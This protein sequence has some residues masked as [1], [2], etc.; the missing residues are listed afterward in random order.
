M[1]RTDDQSSTSEESDDEVERFEEVMAVPPPMRIDPFEKERERFIDENRKFSDVMEAYKEQRILE[2]AWTQE[3]KEI[4]LQRF[5]FL[6][7]QCYSLCS[8][9]YAL[10]G[11]FSSFLFFFCYQD[12][13][14][15][16]FLYSSVISIP[17]C[18]GLFFLH[19]MQV[20][21]PNL[22]FFQMMAKLFG[23]SF[24]FCCCRFFQ[25]PKDF[26]RIASFIPGKTVKDCVA[27]YVNNKYKLKL[28]MDLWSSL[29]ASANA[30]ISSKLSS[31]PSFSMDGP[32]SNRSRPSI[33][34][35]STSISSMQL[36]PNPKSVGKSNSILG[37]PPSIP[38]PMRTQMSQPKR[39]RMSSG[40]PSLISA[41]SDPSSSYQSQ[42]SP[43]TEDDL[44]AAAAAAAAAADAAESI[45][46]RKV[47]LRFL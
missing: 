26:H 35:R 39:S 27:F 25:F 11:F 44:A 8:V 9:I 38:I 3:Q 12:P 33:L 7:T 24:L 45:A 42:L 31:D 18:L 40:A 15:F 22:D 29:D 43:L 30:T 21:S 1:Y 19:V 47:F 5:V 32:Q 10:C 16:F 4:F 20:F 37:T 46:L 28:G 14:E 17:V 6:P 13:L 41:P 23:F 2:R 36:S 34:N